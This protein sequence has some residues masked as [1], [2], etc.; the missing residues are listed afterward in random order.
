MS[1]MFA[2]NVCL[3]TQVRN[4]SFS[5]SP[6]IPHCSTFEKNK[7][8]TKRKFKGLP[9]SDKIRDIYGKAFQ[10]PFLAVFVIFGTV[11]KVLDIGNNWSWSS[12]CTGPFCR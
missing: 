8:Q 6:V 11:L 12:R 2:S 9:I 7:I 3:K 4:L 1:R 5:F 10:C